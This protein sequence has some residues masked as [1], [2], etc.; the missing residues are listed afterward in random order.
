MVSFARIGSLRAVRVP[1]NSLVPQPPQP[2]MPTAAQLSSTAAL[3]DYIESSLLAFGRCA[4][5]RGNIYFATTLQLDFGLGGIISGSGGAGH[6]LTTAPNEFDPAAISNSTRL[7]YTGPGN[8]PAIVLRAINFPTFEHFSLERVN[9]GVGILVQ[10]VTGELKHR[11]TRCGFHNCTI[12]QQ[13]GEAQGDLNCGDAVYSDCSWSEC[14]NGVVVKNDQGLNF[15]FESNCGF[16]SVDT[17]VYCQFGGNVNIRDSATYNVGTMLRVD[18]SG[19]NNGQFNISGLRMD[20]DGANRVPIVV[21]A[22][23]VSTAVPC[24]VLVDG[25]TVAGSG[26]HGSPTHYFFRQPNPKGARHSITVRDFVTD[27]QGVTTPAEVGPLA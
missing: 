14:N 26:A 16:V 23:R 7:I 11:Y 13:W 6:C 2:N 15:T 4:L 10:S 1:D 19:P 27:V 17:A 3:K 12:G 22:S 18:A 25:V 5:P 24:R 21:D 8:T 20:R 9:R